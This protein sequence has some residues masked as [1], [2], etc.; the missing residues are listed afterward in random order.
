MPIRV[1]PSISMTMVGA[2]LPGKWASA[3]VAHDWVRLAVRL[4]CVLFGLR[5]TWPNGDGTMS[6]QLPS[7]LADH[8][9]LSPGK[10]S[11]LAGHLV[12]A[13]RDAQVLMPIALQRAALAI[14]TAI[15]VAIVAYA[16][17]PTGLSRHFDARERVAINEFAEAL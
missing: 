2:A 16:D 5:I 10:A 12:F 4:F 15:A 17:K 3:T 14:A 6:L 13:Q 9:R 11:A 7:I 1:K 8:F